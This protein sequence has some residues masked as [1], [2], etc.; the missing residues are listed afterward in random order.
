MLL[1]WLD[2]YIFIFSDYSWNSIHA[3]HSQCHQLIIGLNRPPKQSW[4]WSSD[5]CC[6][7]VWIAKR[8]PIGIKCLSVTKACWFEYSGAD[9]LSPNHQ[10]TCRWACATI[11]T[12]DQTNLSPVCP[13]FYPP[14]HRAAHPVPKLRRAPCRLRQR[15]MTPWGG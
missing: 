14:C 8:N 6:H 10:V 13:H 15:W 9:R 12:H 4:V 1:C 11:L 3:L 2:I 7:T 5:G